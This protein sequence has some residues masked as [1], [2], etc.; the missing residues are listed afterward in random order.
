[1]ERRETLASGE[2][3]GGRGEIEGRVV[4]GSSADMKGG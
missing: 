4:F 1:M 2:G 3:E